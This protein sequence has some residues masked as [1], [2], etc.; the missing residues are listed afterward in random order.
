MKGGKGGEGSNRRGLPLVCVE[1][2]E[3]KG[4]EEE[5]KEWNMPVRE[6][7][8]GGEAGKGRIKGRSKEKRRRERK[9][10]RAMKVR[11]VSGS[12]RGEENGRGENE[13]RR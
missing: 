5:E 1:G 12:V 2:K 4:R 13:N 10:E 11:G 6:E 3:E 9:E 7:D 8:R